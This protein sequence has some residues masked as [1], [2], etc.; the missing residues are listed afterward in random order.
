M[1]EKTSH[2]RSGQEGLMGL[3][4]D[5][6][7]LQAYNNYIEEDNRRSSN[8]DDRMKQAVLGLSRE[9]IM[10]VLIA[11][12]NQDLTAYRKFHKKQLGEFL[13]GFN[14]K[15]R[16]KMSHI[17]IAVSRR[18]YEL[19]KQEDRTRIGTPGDPEITER[20]GRI[21]SGTDPHI[22]EPEVELG[23]T[24]DPREDY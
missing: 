21:E 17:A 18:A 10:P 13:G 16:T 24:P 15:E 2:T 14:G 20:M 7:M 8:L 12:P 6:L 23:Y 19:V 5:D 11:K 22:W 4:T 9:F 3:V 1:K